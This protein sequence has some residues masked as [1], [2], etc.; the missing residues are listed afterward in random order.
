[1]PKDYCV[2]CG[3]PFKDEGKGREER[4]EEIGNICRGCG[5]HAEKMMRKRIEEN[6]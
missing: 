3:L 4:Y 2:S 6:Q 1:M 5:G